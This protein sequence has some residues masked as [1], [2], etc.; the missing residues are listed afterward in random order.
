MK[1]LSI[2]SI[3]LP[4]LAIFTLFLLGAC[5]QSTK[6]GY[7]QLINQDKK[8]DIRVIV[9]YQGDKIL[10][11]DSTSVLPMI[12][13][14]FDEPKEQL[15]KVIDEYDKKFKDVKGFSHSAEYKDDYVV[16]KTKIDYTKADLKELQE[17]Q[18]I[19]AQENQNVDYIG[20]KTT[21]KT[22]KSNG[23]KEVKDGKF[24]ELK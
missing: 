9:E 3:L 19:A 21:L 12:K 13:R 1:K 20:Y 14:K 24:E 18:L 10:S 16:E 4:L 5:G 2:K 22:F 6:K 17:N 11:T 7:L 15:K 23:F 8:T